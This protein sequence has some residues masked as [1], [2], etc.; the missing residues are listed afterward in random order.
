MTATPITTIARQEIGGGYSMQRKIIVNCARLPDGE[1][2][3]MALYENGD[4]LET[5]AAQTEETAMNLF[6]SV[7]QKY[8]QPLQK[9]VFAAHMRPEE[10]YTVL[11][12]NDFGYPVAR[13]ILFKSLRCTTWAQY[14]DAVEIHCRPYRKR[15]D[16]KL[17]LYNKSFAIYEGWH[18]L[19]DDAWQTV[20]SRTEKTT[21]T[22]FNYEC[23]S[24][25]YMEDCLAAMPQPLAVYKDYKTGVNGKLYA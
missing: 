6:D 5:V 11:S 20:V 17:R 19:P 24:A 21:V 22:K 16:C 3:I 1:F 9:A 4:E 18:D 15:S 14:G 12:L 25:N 10:K 2:E 13:K 7:L 23:Y 8:L